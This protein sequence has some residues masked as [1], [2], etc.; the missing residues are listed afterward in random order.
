MCLM[1]LSGSLCLI[2][3]ASQGL[4][5]ALAVALAGKGARLVL[6]ARSA[7]GLGK[8]VARCETLGANVL[9]EALD[10]SDPG[11]VES[12][13]TRVHEEAGPCDLL[14]GNA[15]LIHRPAPLWE[16]P[17]E[18][19]EEVLRVNVCGLATVLRAFLPPMVERGSGFVVNLSST[20]GRSGAGEFT[21]YCASKF[22]VEGLTQALADE[23]PSGLC[24]VSLNPG[25]I[26][27]PMLDTAFRGRTQGCP[28]PQEW[29]KG[30]VT[31]LAQL[32]PQ[33]HGQACS[34]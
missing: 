3:G 17:S 31:F 2:T 20:W 15:A 1:Q 24:V 14:Y 26:A 28:T 11:A 30:A 7:T 23:V 29:V 12:F 5:K 19:F 27:T 33:H 8:T 10:V 9:H 22:A 32:G 16:I 13:A 18:E 25:V 6:C 4:G 21:A 34:L